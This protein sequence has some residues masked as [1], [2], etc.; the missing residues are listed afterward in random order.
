MWR[1]TIF[2]AAVEAGEAHVWL[3]LARA[4][5]A[6]KNPPFNRATFAHQQVH[7]VP[8]AE[9]DLMA[10]T[11]VSE[12]TPSQPK[13]YALAKACHKF[14]LDRLRECQLTTLQHVWGLRRAGMLVLTLRTGAAASYC[15]SCQIHRGAKDFDLGDSLGEDIHRQARQEPFQISGLP[16]QRGCLVAAE[17]N[18]ANS[19]EAIA[20]QVHRCGWL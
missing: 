15:C 17:A 6:E 10:L 14:S 2:D 7:D 18:L 19:L 1:R 3:K 5:S 4:L 13:A 9:S 20:N 12:V 8:Q 16:A 11:D